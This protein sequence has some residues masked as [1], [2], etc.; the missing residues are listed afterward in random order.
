VPSITAMRA[1]RRIRSK[2]LNP[3]KKTAHTCT[4]SIGLFA[5]GRG[6]PEWAMGSRSAPSDKRT[7]ARE[8][9]SKFGELTGLRIDLYRPAMLFDNDVV[10][11]GQA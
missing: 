2:V 4:R 6:I 3:R 10:T 8:N 1:A 11:D 9:D 5:P 7:R